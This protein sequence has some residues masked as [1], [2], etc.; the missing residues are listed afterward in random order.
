M[1][2]GSAT[3]RSTKCR[4]TTG[5]GNLITALASGVIL[6]TASLSRQSERLRWR[7]SSSR[8]RR[9]NHTSGLT[10]QLTKRRSTGGGCTG[11]SR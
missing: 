4:A 8:G 7:R 10:G 11:I 3:R 5:M 1:R 6:S 2:C 9:P